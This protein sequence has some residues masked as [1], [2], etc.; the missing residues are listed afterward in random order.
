MALRQNFEAVH[1]PDKLTSRNPYIQPAD[2]C[3]ETSKRRKESSNFPTNS[4]QCFCVTDAP[5]IHQSSGLV[6][7]NEFLT[8]IQASDVRSP[9]IDRWASGLVGWDRLSHCYRRAL[10]PVGTDKNKTQQRAQKER[11]P[12]DQNP[13]RLRTE[14]RSL[15]LEE[16]S[17]WRAIQNYRPLDSICPSH[18]FL[19]LRLHVSISRKC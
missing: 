13:P 19:R 6:V 4:C 8:A 3:S 7:V 1:G 5:E 14:E 17:S 16:I 11:G 9:A 12:E 10:M 15:R 18:F 2:P